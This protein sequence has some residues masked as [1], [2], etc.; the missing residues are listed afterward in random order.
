MS[1][2]EALSYPGSPTLPLLGLQSLAPC[3]VSGPKGEMKKDPLVLLPRH[4]C[5]AST[6][7]SWEFQPELSNV[8]DRFW[9]GDLGLGCPVLLSVMPWGVMEGSHGG[10]LRWI[11]RWAVN[12]EIGV[13]CNYVR[14]PKAWKQDLSW[15]CYRSNMLK[16]LSSHH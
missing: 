10:F 11:T 1:K 2:L 6:V 15:Y 4:L 7:S 14:K 13:V 5:L 9:N 16:A 12:W 3:C 8:L